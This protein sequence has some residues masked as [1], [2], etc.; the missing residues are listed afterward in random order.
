MLNANASFFF[1]LV[2][3]CLLVC[4]LAF[5]YAVERQ[6]QSHTFSHALFCSFIFCLQL[7][8]V[9]LLAATLLAL[10]LFSPAL[11]DSKFAA[12]YPLFFAMAAKMLVAKREAAFVRAA[13][14]RKRVQANA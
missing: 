9:P 4:W 12:T 8:A 3:S 10:S 14:R 2:S 5:A 11:F 1:F 7:A 6:P 13:R